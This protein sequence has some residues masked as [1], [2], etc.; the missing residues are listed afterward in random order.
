[1]KKVLVAAILGLAAV[2]TVKAQGVVVLYN[3]D[4]P[5]TLITYGAGSGGTLGNGLVQG[6][7]GNWTIGIYGVAGSSAAAINSTFGGSGSGNQTVAG[8]GGLVLNAATTT[9]ITGSPGLFGPAN[10]TFSSFS[11][12]GTFVIVAYNGATYDTS[13][14]RGHSAAFQM[15]AVAN[16]GTPGIVG[17]SMTSFA[18]TAVPE[19]STF[20]LAGLGLAGLLIFRRRK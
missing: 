10:A 9:L 6:T 14:V 20:A 18:V 15:N 3:Y 13:A 2:A 8:V 17:G 16:P 19:P 5:T 7:G 1:M 11:G 4:N 12:A